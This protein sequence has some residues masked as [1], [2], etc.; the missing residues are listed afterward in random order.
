MFVEGATSGPLRPL[1][2]PSARWGAGGVREGICVRYA[3]PQTPKGGGRSVA[4]GSV[5]ALNG[6][7]AVLVRLLNLVGHQ[8]AGRSLV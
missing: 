3:V 8:S 4:P 5:S 1:C 2:A 7:H 6:E